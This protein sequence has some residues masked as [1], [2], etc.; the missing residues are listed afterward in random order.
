MRVKVIGLESAYTIPGRIDRASRRMTHSVADGMER[1][2]GVAS[3]SRQIAAAT[4]AEVGGAGAVIIVGAGV[5][6][7]RIRDQGGSI[8]PRTAQVLRFADGSFR[9]HARQAGIH[10]MQAADQAAGQ[11]TDLS[12][13]KAFTVI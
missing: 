8:S 5:P 6:F 3:R 10:Y 1:A 9:P 2:I 12:F 7:A 13:V 11:I 4:H